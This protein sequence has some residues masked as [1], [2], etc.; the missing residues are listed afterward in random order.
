MLLNNKIYSRWLF[1][2]SIQQRVEKVILK[3]ANLFKLLVGKHYQLVICKRI[4][5]GALFDW[6]GLDWIGLDW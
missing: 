6:T 2:C 3:R 4:P 1:W 5:A